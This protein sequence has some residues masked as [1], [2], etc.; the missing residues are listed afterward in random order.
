MCKR[1][2]TFKQIAIYAIVFSPILVLVGAWLFSVV[3]GRLE[4]VL[5]PFP[6][7]RITAQGTV[8]NAPLAIG[9]GHALAID[10][11]GYL[12][13]WGTNTFGQLGDGTTATRHSPVRIMGDVAAVAAHGN[14]SMAITTNG[15]LYVWGE[16][17]A[18]RGVM[19]SNV[20][21]ATMYNVRSVSIGSSYATAVAF[22]NSLWSWG[23][24]LSGQLG[25]GT[26]LTRTRPRRITDGIVAVSSAPLFSVAATTH[27]TLVMWGAN[28]SGQLGIRSTVPVQVFNNLS[29]F[30]VGNTH[31]LAICDEGVLWGWGDNNTRQVSREIIAH[32]TTPVKI[33]DGVVY[34]LAGNGWS[35]AISADNALWAWGRHEGAIRLEP[36]KIMNDVIAV[37]SSS[38]R[39]FAITANN[40]LYAWGNN[41]G[42]RLGDGTT[43]HRPEP[44]WVMNDVAYVITD[45]SRTFAIC[46]NGALWAWGTNR[47]GALGDGTAEDRYTPVMIMDRVKLP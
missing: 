11:E 20:P 15:T 8:S 2:R 36:E 18:Q 26:T 46:I 25:D 22:D 12:W 38:L 10:A 45:S 27:N 44:V 17:L 4:Y 31:T 1:K 39:T 30:S 35:L 16:R 43:E 47:N 29:S 6:G 32:Q 21:V 42:G 41:F 28:S 40:T 3:Y 14:I 33:M 19:A 24:N 37:S 9:T 34:A 5:T 7:S 13:A 23:M